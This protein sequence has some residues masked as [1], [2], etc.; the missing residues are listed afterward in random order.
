MND[1]FENVVERKECN[2]IILQ[3]FTGSKKEQVS[4]I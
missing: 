1:M 4:M 3:F 2:D